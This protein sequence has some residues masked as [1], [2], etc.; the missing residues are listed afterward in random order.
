MAVLI[1][2]ISIIIR[3]DS[4]DQK[5]PGGWKALFESYNSVWND[6]FYDEKIVCISYRHAPYIK[7]FIEHL[8]NN[9]LI[10]MQ[11]GQ[12]T[13]IAIVDSIHGLLTPATWL[14][15]SRIEDANEKGKI[16]VA[17]CWIFKGNS[18]EF[19]IHEFKENSSLC[20]PEYWNYTGSSSEKDFEALQTK[21]LKIENEDQYEKERSL[22]IKK[23][24]DFL[25]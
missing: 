16:T 22:R 13:D 21:D 4:L 23:L 17:I 7:E 20:T 14:E 3:K 6:I 5:F 8:E 25:K 1:E 18:K 12:A 24:E 2:N 11:N 9:G 15:F 19:E 10:F